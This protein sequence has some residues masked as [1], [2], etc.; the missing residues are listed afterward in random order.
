MR[1]RLRLKHRPKQQLP[2]NYQ[3]L[4]SDW[5]FKVLYEADASF[6][7]Y[8]TEMGYGK[9]NHLFKYFCFS[10][11]KPKRYLL[12]QKSNRFELTYGPTELIL[13][14]YMPRVASEKLYTVLKHQA[15][16]LVHL[17]RT[18]T[19]AVDRISALREPTFYPRHRFKCI[20]PI[21]VT[22]GNPLGPH[23]NYIDPAEKDYGDIFKYN[24]W[25]KS[26]ELFGE[27]H[28]KMDDMHFSIMDAKVTGKKWR[29]Q[30]I[31]VKGKMYHFEWAAPVE[32]TRMAYFAGFG[33]QSANLGMGMVDFL[34]MR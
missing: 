25:H 3:H 1:V 21:C 13:S 7:G 8:L 23:P 33:V 30:D 22:K 10:M 27:N 34:S 17:D 20:T 9:D 14:F 19:F 2:I 12:D 11:L 15:I 28:F 16:E 4:I 6:S 32:L 29:I 18:I 31:E 24:L 5:I 26:N